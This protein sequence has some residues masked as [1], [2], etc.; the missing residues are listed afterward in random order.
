[1]RIEALIFMP[2]MALS[3]SV[4][5]IVGQSLGA[6]KSERAFKA[7]WQVTYVGVAM[8]VVMA[9][10]LFCGADFLAHVMSN[11]PATILYSRR[12]L[13]INSL[14]EPFLAVSMVLTGALQGAGDTRTPMWIT[15][16]TNWIVRLPLAWVLCINCKMGPDGVWIAMATSITLSATLATWRYQ[17]R[18]WLKTRL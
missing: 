13:Q 8:M 14:T 7:G 2:L 4:A 15:I 5:S 11:D 17:S 9:M 1:M 10:C 12:Y 3:L 18:A 6:Q 16:F